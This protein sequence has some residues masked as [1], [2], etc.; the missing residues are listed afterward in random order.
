M[1]NPGATTEL[2]AGGLGAGSNFNFKTVLQ[3]LVQRGASDLH[4]KVGRPPTLRLHGQL[5]PLDMPALRP[6]D[7]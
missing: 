4:L 3:Q 6:E 7:L 1:G 5:T 2:A